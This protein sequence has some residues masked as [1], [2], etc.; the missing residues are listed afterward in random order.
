MRCLPCFNNPIKD[1]PVHDLGGLK[2][3]LDNGD[4]CVIHVPEAT[5]RVKEIKPGPIRYALRKEPEAWRPPIAKEQA[6]DFN[7]RE[8]GQEG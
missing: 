6:R 4:I 3:L 2:F 8:P 1:W 7:E 5:E